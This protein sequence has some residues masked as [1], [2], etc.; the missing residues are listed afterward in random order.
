MGDIRLREVFSA[1]NSA[2][3]KEKRKTGTSNQQLNELFEKQ[4]KEYINKKSGTSKKSQ[5]MSQKRF[6]LFK[7]RVKEFRAFAV[8]LH[9][10]PSD[11]FN[12][13]I[14]I[15]NAGNQTGQRKMKIHEWLDNYL[16][17]KR[18]E[19]SLIKTDEFIPKGTSCWIDG[20]EISSGDINP[21]ASTAFNT[22][23]TKNSE[24][25]EALA[26]LKIIVDLSKAPWNYPYHLGIFG[27]F[28]L[29]KEMN[30]NKNLQLERLF[31][32]DELPEELSSYRH[33]IAN[34][35]NKWINSQP[36]QNV[37]KPIKVM[38]G[39][40]G[41]H[42]NLNE[43]TG[44]KTGTKTVIK[45]QPKIRCTFCN[46]NNE[47]VL[48]RQNTHLPSNIEEISIKRLQG[49]MI[50]LCKDKHLH[51]VNNEFLYCPNLRVV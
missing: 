40:I 18:D 9:L 37:I 12:I 17:N 2:I 30:K 23:R 7:Q 11:I 32:V 39:D 15:L 47:T 42:V 33:E 36:N 22:Y 35:M 44:T 46:F 25:Y 43:K 20:V 21:K 3:N 48:H 50:Y 26:V 51:D 49:S 34:M 5:K 24:I 13:Q 28:E 16:E 6:Y 41:L 14:N 19:A 1:I 10:I 45:I 8:A 38:T 4:F 29:L 31:I 27:I